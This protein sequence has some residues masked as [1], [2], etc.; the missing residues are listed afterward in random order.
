MGRP[1]LPVGTWGDIDVDALPGGRYRARTRFR[2]LDGRTRQV[3]RRGPTKGA[4]R[5]ALTTYLTERTAPAASDLTGSTR[6]QAVSEVWTEELAARDVAPA[7]RRRYHEVLTDHILPALGGLTLTEC[8]VTR[9]DRFLKATTRNT[10]PATAKLCRSVLSGML[11]IA[12]RHGAIPANPVRDAAGINPKRTEDDEPR[13]LTPAEIATARDAIRRWQDGEPAPGKARRGRPPTQDL[14]DIVD[15]LLGTGARIGE[16]LGLQWAGVDL[17]AGTVRIAG[18]V[19]RDHAGQW[20]RQTH[21]KTSSSR[22]LLS[23][24]QHAVDLLL[25]RRVQ[26]VAGNTGDLV[27]PS[28]TGTVR[29]PATV[30]VQLRKVLAPIGLAWVTPRSFR[31]TVATW[32]EQEVDLETA[33]QQLGHDGT[34]TTRRHYV[35]PTHTGP[36]VQTILARLI[37]GPE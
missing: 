2:D 5:R 17:E 11:G 6:V 12:A 3:E 33:A 28:T 9:V 27:F 1:P 34:E 24:P 10:G 21:P 31:K 15:T 16:V 25:R 14:L 29:D 23:L 32:L 19:A 35:Q 13:A 4:A 30:R 36:T 22:R 20:V 7:T 37:P 18:T 8:T 26:M